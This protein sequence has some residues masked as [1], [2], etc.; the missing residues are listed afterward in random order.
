[1]I[2]NPTRGLSVWWDE[3]GASGKGTFWIEEKGKR[4]A[5]PDGEGVALLY[6]H[7]GNVGEAITTLWE[8]I[9]NEPL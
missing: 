6:V 9:V 2:V 5:Y 3:D 4:R 1:M 7:G 8:N